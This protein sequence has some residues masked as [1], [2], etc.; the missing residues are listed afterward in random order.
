MAL[1]MPP[2]PNRGHTCMTKALLRPVED[3]G[4]PRIDPYSML[5]DF[6]NSFRLAVYCFCATKWAWVHWP[7][8]LQYIALTQFHLTSRN[9]SKA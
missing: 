7:M 1:R 9:L 5:A 8:R 2:A 3:Y 4:H 6:H